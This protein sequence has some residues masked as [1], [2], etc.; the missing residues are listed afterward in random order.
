MKI[1]ELPGDPGRRQK[2]KRVGRGAGSGTGKTCGRGHKGAQSRKGGPGDARAHRFE[3]GQTP[4]LRRLPKRGFTNSDKIVYQLVNVGQLNVFEDGAEV[5]AAS[6]KEKGIISST[7]KHIKLLG[8]G[9][10]ERK[11]TIKVDRASKSAADAVSKV[12][13]SL[14]AVVGKEPGTKASKGE[15]KMAPKAERNQD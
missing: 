13:G 10:L 1:H 11:L 7:N 8:Q 12:G 5:T 14:E 4:L 6:L 15:G 9:D 3:G 2:R